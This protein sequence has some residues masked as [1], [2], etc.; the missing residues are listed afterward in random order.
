MGED[1]RKGFLTAL[2]KN[3]DDQSAR[4]AYVDWLDERGEHDEAERHRNF[5]MAKQWLIRFAKDISY[6]GEDWYTYEQVVQA[7]REALQ[8]GEY[9]W[10]TDAGADFFRGGE[11]NRREF[12]R[13]WS[14]VTGVPVSE[15]AV[16]NTLF[17]CSC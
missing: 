10:G 16:E 8:D 6:E 2:A 13:N 15:D 9:C 11:A 1:D 5:P 17:R 14:I 7:G 4:N 12:W 3:E